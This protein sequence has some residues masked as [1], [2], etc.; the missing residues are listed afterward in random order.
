MTKNYILV[1]EAIKVTKF[2]KT[3]LSIYCLFVAGILLSMSCVKQ[4]NVEEPLKYEPDPALLELDDEE[5]E[6]LPEDTG[7]TL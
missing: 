6:D 7:E 5:L 2:G 4:K 3:L 1:M